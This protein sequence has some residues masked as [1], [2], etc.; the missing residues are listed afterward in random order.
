MS[1]FILSGPIS[2]IL[3][4]VT[5]Y[6]DELSSNLATKAV[7][8]SMQTTLG[9]VNTNVSTILGRVPAEVAPKS[10]LDTVNTNLSTVLTD[11]GDMQPKV[12]EIVE[13]TREIVVDTREI[14]GDVNAVLNDTAA[15]DSRLNATWAGRLD[16]NIT[17]RLS[18]CIRVIRVVG[19]YNK[20]GSANS[21]NS[22]F[23]HTLYDAAISA[24]NITNYQKAVFIGTCVF[25][26]SPSNFYY[27]N[28]VAQGHGRM[29]S[30][31]VLRLYSAVDFQ[32][33]GGITSPRCTF[34][35][36]LVEFY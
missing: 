27:S 13:D 4:H 3:N 12:N 11:T 21:G 33:L 17:T 8:A 34:S 15:L 22:E 18:S 7:Q 28:Q 35:G 26:V 25:H 2:Q 36:V 5:T 30:N 19:G 31:T 20:V 6:L 29:I 10:T 9:T 16:A 14:V 1:A 23:E 32:A 24:G